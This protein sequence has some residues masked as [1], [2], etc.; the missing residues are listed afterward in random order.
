FR[1][2]SV[3]NRQGKPAIGLYAE[4]TDYDEWQPTELNF[5]L[6]KLACKLEPLNPFVAAPASVQTLFLKHMG[7]EAF[8]RALQ[9]DGAR[10]DVAAF[11]AEWR[12]RAKIY[13]LQS[14]R[15]W[16]YQ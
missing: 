9:R 14:R 6:M 7:S 15:Y 13:Q 8:L 11:V 16:I 5:Y 2:V 1:R 12:E 4:I 10:T 3:P